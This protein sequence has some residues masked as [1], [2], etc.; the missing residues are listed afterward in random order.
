MVPVEVKVSTAGA[1]PIACAWLGPSPKERAVRAAAEPA[2]QPVPK[3]CTDP[4]GAA[5]IRSEIQSVEFG[6]SINWTRHSHRSAE[7]ARLH[8]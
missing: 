2:P 5:E 1:S 8:T 7:L 4:V 6:D 3:P